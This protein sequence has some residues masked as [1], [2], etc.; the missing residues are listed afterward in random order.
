MSSEISIP[1]SLNQYGQ[2]ATTDD[3]NVQV[4]QHVKSVVATE[5]G[6]RVQKP[7]YGVPTRQ[8]MF[9]PGE[10]TTS[11]E[12]YRDIVTQLAI[13]EPS[14]EVISINPTVAE[15]LTGICPVEVDFTQSFDPNDQALQATIQIGGTVVQS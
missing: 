6:E 2:V 1:F 13:W 9:F 10:I 14:V 11:T 3:P 5:P 8:Y 4:M 7:T 15:P 12:L